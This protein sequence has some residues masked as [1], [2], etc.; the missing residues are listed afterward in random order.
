MTC[1]FLPLLLI[2]LVSYPLALLK[3][4]AGVG[5]VSFFM[6]FYYIRQ[7]RDMD[8]VYGVI[9]SYYAFL[10]LRW[11]RPYALLTVRN[12]RWLTR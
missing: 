8:F 1:I 2:S 7:E 10:F 5:I 11:I 4:V 12:G 6:T 9:Y 3:F